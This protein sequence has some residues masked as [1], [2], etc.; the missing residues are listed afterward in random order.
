MSTTPK[1]PSVSKPRGDRLIS[2]ELPFSK[3]RGPLSKTLPK[4]QREAAKTS[5]MLLKLAGLDELIEYG[6]TYQD[7]PPP[8]TFAPREEPNVLDDAKQLVRLQWLME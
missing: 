6:P 4:Q 3:P 2:S 1:K 5:D 8:Y 7:I